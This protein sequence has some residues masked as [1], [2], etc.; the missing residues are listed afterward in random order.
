MR[1][2][3]VCAL[4]LMLC[5]SA[6]AS[7]TTP[8]WL[9]QVD[10]HKIVTIA[11]GDFSAATY[12]TGELVNTQPPTSDVLTL[13]RLRGGRVET[14][15][16]PASNSVT[17]PPEVLAL[18]PD[19][20]YA[21]VVERLAQRATGQK[22]AR[23]LAP[24]Q[25]LATIDL[26]AAAG[27]T[28]V[29]TAQVGPSAES[30]RMR[31]DGRML[32]ITANSAQAASV[33]LVPFNPQTATLGEPQRFDLASLG[34]RGAATSA[35]RGGVT[36]SFAD[37]HP[38][39]TAIA[40]NI[41]T[42]NRVAFFRLQGNDAAATLQPWGDAV[43]VGPDPFVGRFTPDGQ[44]YITAD[45]G[46]DFA[47]TRIEDRLPRRAS[48]LTVLRL[49]DCGRHERLPGAV[50]DAGSEG[51]AV[52]RDGRLVATVNMRDSAF[53][54]TS[55]RFGLQASVSLFGFDAATGRLSKWQDVLFEGV[56]PEGASFDLSG[57]HLLVTVY[58][59]RDSPNAQSREGGLEVWR[60]DR[61]ERK[62]H[63]LGRL[64]MPFGVHH[65]EV[66]GPSPVQPPLK[67]P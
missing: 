58:E 10:A 17:S 67:T 55:P 27:P 49:Q 33:V 51:L 4:V 40:V 66:A 53:L 41:N 19:G 18:S 38:S 15:S 25:Q 29:A 13:M 62:L 57:R 42:Q 1:A 61:R 28:V 63:H 8:T 6:L 31:P 14:A 46:R 59:Y 45:W 64:P 21:F 16:T 35:P 44:H 12:S 5:C 52:S 22:L 43:D 7:A 24:G 60:I 47:A 39:S 2:T 32:L 54:P 30:V 23:E 37:W 34:V 48:T 26:D 65:V 3:P 36:A 56:L 11:D 9:R 50:S 20:R